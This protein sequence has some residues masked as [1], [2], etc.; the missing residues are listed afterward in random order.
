[1][2]QHEELKDLEGLGEKNKFCVHVKFAKQILEI[3]LQ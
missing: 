2:F 3:W 1:M